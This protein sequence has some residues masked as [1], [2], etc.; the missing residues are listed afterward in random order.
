[1][2]A[3]R[4]MALSLGCILLASFLFALLGT[5]SAP[6]GHALRSIMDVFPVTLIFALP[7]WIFSLPLVAAFKDAEGWRSWAIL[8][9]GTAFGPSFLLIWDLLAQHGR[10]H[11]NWNGDGS[12]L[13]SALIVGF[14]TSLIYVF[15]L[16][17]IDRRSYRRPPPC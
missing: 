6:H 5:K 13:I 17:T 12:F 4:R 8:A 11:I 10:A 1:M 9:I 14:M 16:R 7:A 2:R 3:P 15:A